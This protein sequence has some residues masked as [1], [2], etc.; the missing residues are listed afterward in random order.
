LFEYIIGKG[1]KCRAFV[2]MGGL[3]RLKSLPRQLL[4]SGEIGR[5]LELI[6]AEI[7]NFV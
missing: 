2:K 5:R 3:K 7:A 1:D 4:K 6:F